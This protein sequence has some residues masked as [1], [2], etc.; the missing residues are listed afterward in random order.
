MKKRV[1]WLALGSVLLSSCASSEPLAAPSNLTVTP[2]VN[3]IDLAWEDNSNNE[4]GFRIFR[5]LEG[6]SSF[7]ELQETAPNT[8]SYTDASVTSSGR[9]V[10]EVRAFTSN[11]NESAP[12]AIGEAVA[13]TILATPTNL[14]ATPGEGKID[15]TW[16]DASDNEEGFNI[17]R[18]L[19]SD[20]AF[21][22]TP[23]DSVGADVTTYSD[24]SVS[25]D[26]SYVYQVVAFA[27]SSVSEASN[28]TSPAT[29]TEPEPVIESLEGEWRGQLE[30]VGDVALSVDEN[31]DPDES[32]Q[33]H[34]AR[35]DYLDEEGNSTARV[36]FEC[37]VT[38]P[39]FKCNEIDANGD[40]LG[41][42]DTVITGEFIAEG[43]IS[44][45]FKPFNSQELKE[46]TLEK[47]A[48]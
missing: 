25:V 16:T 11:G 18:K 34:N 14:T 3:K 36:F 15:L 24:T 38:G 26:S 23:L 22:A 37:R 29:P 6:G 30:G 32:I 43:Q 13:I 19:E 10:Y 9:Y 7:T 46:L 1:L 45:T 48:E 4:A 5:K 27:G 20:A 33:R 28:S 41:D 35:F 17:F 31:L 39:T 44:G 2:G 40:V 47:V 42:N 21:P 8:E 12:A